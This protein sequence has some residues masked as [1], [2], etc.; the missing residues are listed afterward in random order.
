MKKI[1]VIEDDPVNILVLYDFLSSRG[2]RTTLARNG[3][4][5]IERFHQDEPDLILIDVQLPRKNGFEVCFEIRRTPKGSDVPI[6]LMS[7]VYT[8][9]QHA[10][11]HAT[12]L[13]AQG[14]LVKPFELPTLLDHVYRL[15]GKP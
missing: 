8:D 13:Q 1:L 9:L 14:Y 6:L 4:D 15:V 2:Y 5:G 7:A 3:I 10:E 11:Q 12:G